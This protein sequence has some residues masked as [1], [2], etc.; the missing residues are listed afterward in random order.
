VFEASAGGVG[1]ASCPDEGGGTGI[2]G[3]NEV[4]S[5]PPIAEGPGG[6]A[7]LGGD[8]PARSNTRGSAWAPSVGSD[9]TLDPAQA[10]REGNAG[11]AGALHVR[12]PHLNLLFRALPSPPKDGFSGD[13]MRAGINAHGFKPVFGSYNLGTVTLMGLCSPALVASLAA[14]ATRPG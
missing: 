7:G 3:G 5:V 11:K 10:A 8:E 12:I 9:T 2:A 1:I 6:G 14:K 4:S 13:S